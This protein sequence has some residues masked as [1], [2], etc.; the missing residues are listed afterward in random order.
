[1]SKK[2]P[3]VVVRLIIQLELNQ[4]TFKSVP[5]I[6]DTPEDFPYSRSEEAYL[7]H[8]DLPSEIEKFIIFQNLEVVAQD[9][10]LLVRIFCISN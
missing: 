7:F 10:E 4:K 5:I 3:L 2:T 9:L 1:M 8:K 6:D